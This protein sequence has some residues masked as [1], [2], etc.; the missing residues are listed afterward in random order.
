MQ[1]KTRKETEQPNKNKEKK[2]HKNGNRG[3]RKEDLKMAQKVAEVK[4][5][6]TL[7]PRLINPRG[8]LEDARV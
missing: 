6:H 7:S 5:T 4:D 2:R 1:I 8:R 3:Q